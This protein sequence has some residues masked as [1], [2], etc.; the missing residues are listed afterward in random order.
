MKDSVFNCCFLPPLPPG[1]EAERT[2]RP[3]NMA[4]APTSSSPSSPPP[5]DK[6]FLIFFDFD[7]TIVDESSDDVVVQ[8]AP[9][10]KLPGWL[11]DSYR[12]GHYNEYMQ[13]VL[14][15]MAEQ[16]VSEAA[17]RAVIEG[18]PASPGILALF[19]HL[20]GRARDFEIVLVS[21]ANAFFIEAWL[22]KAGAC[23]LFAKIF[24]NPA[25][26]DGAG[27]LRLGPYHSHACL[28]C[29]ENMCK[30]AILREYLARRAAERG[31]PFQ[32]VFYVGDGANDF[33]PSLVLGPR[34]TAFPRRDYPMH[35][36]IGQL[37]EARPGD[38]QA[39]VV[40]WESGEDVVARL[41]RLAEER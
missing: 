34:D 19:Q 23:Q 13:R 38:F 17:I 29:P 16:G 2:R 32:R 20:R 4:A 37:H 27:R 31:R 18:I 25:A 3:R 21:D 40:P 30:Q 26:F 10:Q 12:P 35:A 8:A 24:T 33:C 9:G 11:K 5:P 36:L 14:A 7:E 15:Y 41:Q 28:R 1:E 6:R 22:R 39:A